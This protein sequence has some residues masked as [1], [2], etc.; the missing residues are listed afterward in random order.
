MNVVKST[1]GL[2]MA[3]AW[4]TNGYAAY[5]RLFCT[6]WFSAR[7]RRTAFNPHV[8]SPSSNKCFLNCATLIDE[9]ETSPRREGKQKG[10]SRSVESPGL[11]H[12]SGTY[13]PLNFLVHPYPHSNPPQSLW[14]P[15]RVESSE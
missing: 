9:M 8:G 3:Y 12:P 6:S 7:A 13:C 5:F 14:A 10:S 4:S 11:S 2:C 1:Y 15:E